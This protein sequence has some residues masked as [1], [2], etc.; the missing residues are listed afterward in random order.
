MSEEPISSP[1]QRACSIRVPLAAAVAGLAAG[2]GG[3][4]S[5]LD[6]A[7]DEAARLSAL[8]WILFIGAAV[9]FVGVMLLLL[10]AVVANPD[11]RRWLGHRR[12][13]IA[14]G[15]VFPIVTLT[16]LFTF[17][18]VLLRSSNVASR[19]NPISIEVIGEQY[20]WR[21]RY[22]ADGDRPALTTANELRVPVGRAVELAVTSADVVHA[23]WIPNF[24]GKID[25]VPGRV[26]TLRFTVERD[27][28][29][30]G[31]CTEFCGDQHA[32]MA[33]DVIALL[34]EA[35]E[36]WRRGEAGNAREPV[37]PLQE[38]GKIVFA[39]GGCGSCHAVRG[40]EAQGQLGPDLTHIGS[41]RSL[42]AGSYPN[43]VGTLAGWIADT[44]HLKPGA[45][46]PSFSS[47]SGEELR[48]VASYLD[49]LK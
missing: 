1:W 7:A 13:V 8:S 27:G 28:V 35:F 38:F 14:G 18:L 9:I 46:M 6:P 40:T 32:R 26:N 31:I 36:A 39:R 3:V 44:Q 37:T 12:T 20:W 43:N 48:A 23:I 11:R 19:D 30:R 45:R 16:A 17:G 4:Q 22:G 29:Y 21:V 47:F 49:N 33:F 24:A 10:Y 41:R 2:C 5:A 42:G 34:P 25:M 15:L